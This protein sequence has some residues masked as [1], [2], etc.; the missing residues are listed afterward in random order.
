MWQ[1]T[2]LSRTAIAR[3]AVGGPPFKQGN[4]A[5]EEPVDPEEP[6]EASR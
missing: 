2:A 5:D 1:S 4:P 3:I 6:S